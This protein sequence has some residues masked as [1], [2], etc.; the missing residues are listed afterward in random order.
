[1]TSLYQVPHAVY[2]I[3]CDIIIDHIIVTLLYMYLVSSAAYNTVCD[4][5]ID[6]T[7]WPYCIKGIHTLQIA[8]YVIS[9][10]TIL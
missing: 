3:V 2:S 10:L 7:M 5:I 8:L 6:H 4:I 9:L 1:M